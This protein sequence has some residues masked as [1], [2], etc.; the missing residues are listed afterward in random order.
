MTVQQS[1]YCV[2]PWISDLM[3]KPETGNL[4]CSDRAGHARLTWQPCSPPLWCQVPPPPSLQGWWGLCSR[5]TPLYTE[6]E[7]SSCKGEKREQQMVKTKMQEKKENGWSQSLVKPEKW[8][9]REKEIN[10]SDE[11]RR[12]QEAISKQ[13]LENSTQIVTAGKGQKMTQSNTQTVKG[14]MPVNRKVIPSVYSW[15]TQCYSSTVR[16]GIW[17]AFFKEYNTKN[18]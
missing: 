18:V 4:W 14:S 17:K 3:I 11:R 15:C 10:M 12:S 5:R 7:G 16:V 6:K 2:L 13:M 8:G 9:T 1:L